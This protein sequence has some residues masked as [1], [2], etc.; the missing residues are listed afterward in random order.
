MIKQKINPAEKNP[1]SKTQMLYPNCSEM[2]F[3]L[4]GDF[5]EIRTQMYN[6]LEWTI[7]EYTGKYGGGDKEELSAYIQKSADEIREKIKSAVSLED[8][9]QIV[10]EF[11]CNYDTF[12][13]KESDNELL[14][15][16]CNNYGWDNVVKEEVYEEDKDYYNVAGY[17]NYIL[18]DVIDGYE[19]YKR[20]YDDASERGMPEFAFPDKGFKITLENSDVKFVIRGDNIFLID[21]N[22]LIKIPQVKDEVMLNKLK[23]LMNLGN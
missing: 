21:N 9:E 12:F 1:S 6:I 5:E 13:K 17:T 22:N 19:I 10:I 20:E 3:R 11:T 4:S 8:F 7:G 23:L 2:V 16:T 14:V 18:H 15:A